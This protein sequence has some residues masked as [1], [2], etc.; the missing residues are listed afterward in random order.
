MY[1]GVFYLCLLIKEP[2]HQSVRC[3]LPS[4][5]CSLS[6]FLSVVAVALSWASAF[7]SSSSIDTILQGK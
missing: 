5:K 4:L 3:G 6:L 7:F 2:D 1:V